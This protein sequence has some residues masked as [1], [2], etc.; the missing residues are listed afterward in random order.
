MTPAARVIAWAAAI[1]VLSASSYGRVYTTRPGGGASLDS[2]ASFKAREIYGGKFRVNGR[3]AVMTICAGSVSPS[4]T[5]R[6]FHAADGTVPAELRYR[7][8]EG[9]VV[10]AV[11]RGEGERRVLITSA[12]A[13]HSCL[14]FILQS[15]EG[16]LGAA[17]G[18]DIPWPESLPELHAR[19]AP[20]LVVEHLDAKF[21]FA[22]AS[23]PGA[24]VETVLADCR[25]R[26]RGAGWDVEP[27]TD[28]VLAEMPDSGF[29]VLHKKGKTCWVQA[30]A[31]TAD[32]E[33]M[34]TLLCRAE[35]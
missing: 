35:E 16:L 26:L 11:G 28:R 15:A 6:L 14:V 9:T 3:R 21:V 30:R 32:H 33:V 19:Q 20:R 8:S 13:R 12:G 23:V 18:Q 7:S 31:G 34:V 2:P 27:M 5:I 25:E 22:C 29:A 10:G 4:D 24:D 1:G 17:A